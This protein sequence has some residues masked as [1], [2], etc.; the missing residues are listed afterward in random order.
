MINFGLE[1][2]QY[3]EA[4]GNQDPNNPPNYIWLDEDQISYVRENFSDIKTKFNIIENSG[5]KHRI[6]L[7][8]DC[9]MDFFRHFFQ[10]VYS[11]S[12]YCAHPIRVGLSFI[13]LK[14][15]EGMQPQQNV[16]REFYESLE[17]KWM[18]A[19]DGNSVT[20][21]DFKRTVK[22]EY[23]EHVL[24]RFGAPGYGYKSI[25]RNMMDRRHYIL[26]EFLGQRIEDVAM[27]VALNIHIEPFQLGQTVPRIVML[28][29]VEYVHVNNNNEIESGYESN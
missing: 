5:F 20:F 4:Y 13:L 21:R 10:N 24:N 12:G 26:R 9:T 18:L 16:V 3:P 25:L 1:S 14:Q 7:I 28:L 6:C 23:L 15:Y 29:S 11:M 17:T 19:I 2:F 22:F 8:S 27:P